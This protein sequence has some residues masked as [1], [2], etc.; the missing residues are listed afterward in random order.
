MRNSD[1]NRAQNYIKKHERRRRWI[2]FALCLS[3][4]TGTV[5]LYGLNKPAQALTREGSKRV[6][7][8]LQTADNEFEEGL[9]KQTEENKAEQQESMEDEASSGSA[10]GDGFD[11]SAA[12][13]S[14]SSEEQEEKES[15]A[16]GETSTDESSEE[17]STDEEN[18]DAAD[19]A[20]SEEAAE[21]DSEESA[22]TDA[23]VELKEDVVITVLYQDSEGEEIAESK[24]LRI[25]EAFN[26]K[27]PL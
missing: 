26:I 16:S 8:V 14:G 9:I 18:A 27:D 2:A 1:V 13:G 7:L 24:E 6:G 4:L 23:S 12:S 10:S 20:S 19:S 5:T 21:E 11:E 17:T 3:L 15:A 22:S 25:S